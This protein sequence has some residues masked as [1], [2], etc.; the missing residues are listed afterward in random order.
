MVQRIPLEGLRFGR[1]LVIEKAAREGLST[2]YKCQC[3]CGTVKNVRSVSLRGGDTQSCGCMR[4]QQMRAK[5]TTH[6]LYGSPTYASWR[7]MIIR[8]TDPS[9]RQFKDYGGRGITI[10]PE[11]LASFE[12]FLLALGVR[13]EGKTL[14]RKETNGNY[15]PGN[16][17]WSTPTEQNANKRKKTSTH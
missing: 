6:G 14:D 10:C 4:Q 7:A 9:H 3:D 15:E 12:S 2:F 1:L 13:P 16:C 5:K 8:C 11:W 17:K